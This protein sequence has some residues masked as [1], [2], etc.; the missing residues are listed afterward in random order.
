MTRQQLDSRQQSQAEEVR[1]PILRLKRQTRRF[2]KIN[3][4]GETEHPPKNCHPI[5]EILATVG[6]RWTAPILA[7]LFVAT[8]ANRGGPD[9]LAHPFFADVFSYSQ[10]CDFC[11]D[12]YAPGTV[13]TVARQ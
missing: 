4:L 9:D 7:A 5:A 3:K 6:D 13:P 2:F 12:G 8:F 11:R 10:D 1:R